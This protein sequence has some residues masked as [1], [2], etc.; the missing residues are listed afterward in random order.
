V[1]PI[2]IIRINLMNTKELSI[3]A[4]VAS[5]TGAM[6]LRGNTADVIAGSARTGIILPAFALYKQAARQLAAKLDPTFTEDSPTPRWA[7]F[8][9]GALAGATATTILFPLE[10]A[11]TRMAMECKV[12]D[13]VI[14]C[15]TNLWSTEGAS[16]VYR[17][18]AT[19]LIGVMPFNAIKLTSYDV[20]R[21]KALAACSHAD[22]GASTRLPPALTA[23][24]GAV[25]GVTAATACFPIEVV[26]R[27]KMIG[28]FAGVSLVPAIS[29]LARSEGVA[30][31][32]RGV[33]IN[34]GKV[35]VGTG[36]SFVIYE[37]LKDSLRVDGR[38]PPWEKVSTKV[39]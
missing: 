35:S 9:A 15:L 2:E 23:A 1:A 12:G 11:R 6:A 4:A 22:E 24:V 3:K 7:V 8:G 25:S 27:R 10:V 30:A 16:A 38:T 26:R 21:D 34:A 37:L 20:L 17:G 19:S 39:G 13:S 28:E 33:V 29:S 36:L 32:Y 14:G 5:L 18:L 31:L